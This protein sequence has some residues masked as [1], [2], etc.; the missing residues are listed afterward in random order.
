MKKVDTMQEQMGNVNIE[1]KAI[2]TTTTTKKK[3]WKSKQL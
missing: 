3:Y 1:M 2:T